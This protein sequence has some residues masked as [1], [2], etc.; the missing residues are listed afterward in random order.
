ML[1]SGCGTCHVIGD[2]GE[3]GKVGPDLSNIGLDAANRDPDLT[4]A[5]FIRQSILNPEASTA[6]ICPNGS[7][8][9]N[10]MPND[11]AQRLAHEQ[12]EILVEFLVNQVSSPVLTGTALASPSATSA[13][14]VASSVGAT[15]GEQ[16]PR[17]PTTAER[18]DSVVF[19][20]LLTTT[21]FIFL[22]LFAVTGERKS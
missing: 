3:A 6:P 13:A 21:I 19:V 18:S 17:N 11:Y 15:D 5:E 7:C 10:I 12:V 1:N 4:A 8:Q 22:I 16:K 9:G 2:F 20:L 14:S